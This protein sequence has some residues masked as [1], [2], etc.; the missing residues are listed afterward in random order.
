MAAPLMLPSQRPACAAGVRGDPTA[1]QATTLMVGA[2]AAAGT[3]CTTLAPSELSYALASV[4]KVEV[5]CGCAVQCWMCP[6]LPSKGQ[7]RAHLPLPLQVQA[8]PYRRELELVGHQSSRQ[9]LP[10]GLTVHQCAHQLVQLYDTFGRQACS[11]FTP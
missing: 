9:P 2:L 4:F 7:A 11:S 8:P 10:A 3:P 1:P 5:R 6:S